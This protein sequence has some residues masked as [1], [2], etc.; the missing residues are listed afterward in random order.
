MNRTLSASSRWAAHVQSVQAT[1]AKWPELPREAPIAF[2]FATMSV[3]QGKTR[4][5]RGWRSAL[6]W[7]DNAYSGLPIGTPPAGRVV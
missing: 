7:N 2:E 3:R 6:Q 1:R 5:L 4:G